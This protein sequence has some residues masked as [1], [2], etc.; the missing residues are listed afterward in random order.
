MKVIYFIALYNYGRNL[1][2]WTNCD[3]SSESVFICGSNWSLTVGLHL[4]YRILKSNQLNYRE[5]G[6]APARVGR[7]AEALE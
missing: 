1:K 7:I 4:Q 5:I 3:A 6:V 2:S